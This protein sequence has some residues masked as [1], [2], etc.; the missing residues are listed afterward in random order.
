MLP[1]RLHRGVQ[2]AWDHVP[3]NLLSLVAVDC[4][5]PQGS[6]KTVK[7]FWKIGARPPKLLLLSHKTKSLQGLT[8]SIARVTLPF[9]Q[10]Q[11]V[12]SLLLL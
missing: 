4:R 1:I 11:L 3:A 5:P 7:R 12:P 6:R 10:I 8:W 2:Q 9:T